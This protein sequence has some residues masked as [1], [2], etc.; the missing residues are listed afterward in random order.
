MCSRVTIFLLSTFLLATAYS[1]EAQQRSR[2][3]RIG[4]FNTGSSSA[5]QYLVDAFRQGLIEHG[6][7][8][9]RNIIIE[10][11]WAEGI[12][13]RLTEL[14]ADLVRLRVDVIMRAGETQGSVLP[15]E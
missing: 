14:A 10:C 13:E 3:P 7:V 9:G 4:I 5:S 2:I 12:R 6:Y 15:K 1:S 11:R 8:E